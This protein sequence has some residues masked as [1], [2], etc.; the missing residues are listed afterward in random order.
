MAEP[1]Y[2]AAWP[3]HPTR[4]SSPDRENPQCAGGPHCVGHPLQRHLCVLH[5]RAECTQYSCSAVTIHTGRLVNRLERVCATSRMGTSTVPTTTPRERAHR[6]LSMARRIH[7]SSIAS[8]IRPQMYEAMRPA[9]METIGPSS[10]H[11]T[12]C[13]CP[14]R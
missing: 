8:I 13:A 7:Q 11:P 3:R 4:Q 14:S 5:R 10:S 1:P 12:M 6:Y 9:T 2:R